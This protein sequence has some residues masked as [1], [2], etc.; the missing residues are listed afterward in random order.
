MKLTL[1]ANDFEYLEGKASYVYEL[2]AETTEI[3]ARIFAS[4]FFDLGLETGHV[5]PD[6]K[7]F[8]KEK[9]LWL[10]TETQ[11]DQK[12]RTTGFC[13]LH[14]RTKKTARLAASISVVTRGEKLDPTPIAVTLSTE[15]PLDLKAEI[16]RQLSFMLAEY[17][18]DANADD[19]DLSPLDG[20]FEDDLEDVVG[21][22]DEVY[23][24]APDEENPPPDEEEDQ[25]EDVT[26][27]ETPDGA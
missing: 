21:P 9:M 5:D 22:Y 20:D 6:N 19:F 18:S 27:E 11:A 17:G 26:G 24:P 3:S 8:P 13:A 23:E 7:K 14:I 10:S 25:P 1:D 2:P 12:I 15:R 16:R 4:E